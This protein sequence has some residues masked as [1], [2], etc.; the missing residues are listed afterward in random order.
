ML[1][2]GDAD[3]LSSSLIGSVESVTL[4]CVYKRDLEET[5]RVCG[6]RRKK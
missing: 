2:V 5:L 4:L 1:N 6:G 3:A